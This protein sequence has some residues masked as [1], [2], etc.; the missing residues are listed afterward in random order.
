M[1]PRQNVGSIVKHGDV[2]SDF[3]CV[4]NIL[5]VR[6]LSDRLVENVLQNSYIYI[7][8]Q[9]CLSIVLLLLVYWPPFTLLAVCSW[10]SAQSSLKYFHLSKGTGFGVQRILCD[11]S[12]TNV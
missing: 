9:I 6:Y 2:Y 5:Y 8:S 7:M 10:L 1:L 4:F 11:G 3:C 12:L